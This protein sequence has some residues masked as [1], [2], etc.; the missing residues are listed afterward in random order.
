[1][2]GE[3]GSE[4]KVAQNSAAAVGAKDDVD[5]FDVVLND[6]FAMDVGDS[7]ADIGPD[8]KKPAFGYGGYQVVI[9]EVINTDSRNVFESEGQ[10]ESVKFEELDDIALEITQP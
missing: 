3:G 10:A 4:A 7:V 1:M 8:A 5:R 9:D 2:F 6:V